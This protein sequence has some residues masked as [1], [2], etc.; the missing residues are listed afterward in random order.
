MWSHH[1]HHLAIVTSRH[2]N[3]KDLLEESDIQAV[4]E[5]GLGG[6]RCC[7]PCMDPRFVRERPCPGVEGKRHRVR[8]GNQRVTVD[9]FSLNTRART[10]AGG[11][12]CMERRSV[13]RRNCS[14]SRSLRN[15]DRAVRFSGRMK[16]WFPAAL[17]LTGTASPLA[18]SP[19]Y[20]GLK[21]RFGLFKL[22][23][24]SGAF[25]RSDLFPVCGR[26]FR[27]SRRGT[28]RY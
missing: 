7:A 14:P 19:Y 1:S 25:C 27:K 26:A 5:V 13:S 18:L 9:A 16:G 15:Y 21:N 24:L 3:H 12:P 4:S 11:C 17:N 20:P 6:I 28:L 2:A 23:W 10:L 8:P 22:W